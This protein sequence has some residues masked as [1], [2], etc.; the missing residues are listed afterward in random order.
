[1]LKWV[2]DR[3]EHPED[4]SLYKSTPIGYVPKPESLDL[5]GIEQDL[6]G[7]VM[8]KLLAVDSKAYLSEV[9]KARDYFKMFGDRFPAKLTKELDGLEDRL[10]KNQGV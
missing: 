10:K 1:M 8:E 4:T 6:Q 2:V 5:S 3:L 9:N 7:G